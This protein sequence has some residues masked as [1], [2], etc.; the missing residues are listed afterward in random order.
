VVS[1]MWL[2][3]LVVVIIS[4]TILGI[5]ASESIVDL[6]GKQDVSDEQSALY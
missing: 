1:K 3:G 4:G 5:A 2:I 6:L